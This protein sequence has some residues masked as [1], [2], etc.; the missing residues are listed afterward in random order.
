MANQPPPPPVLGGG[1]LGLGTGD[2]ERPGRSTSTTR[3]TV[4][5]GMGYYP[6]DKEPTFMFPVNDLEVSVSP[7]GRLFQPPPLARGSA[8]PF[9]AT[10]YDEFTR[11]WVNLSIGRLSQKTVPCVKYRS[12]EPPQYPADDHQVPDKDKFTVGTNPDQQAGSK[13]VR[14]LHYYRP[15]YKGPR[16]TYRKSPDLK[17]QLLLLDRPAHFM[18]MEIAAQALT[19]KVGELEP[20]FC[21]LALY[22][23]VS[24]VGKKGAEV[25]LS[26]SGRVS[27]TFWFDMNSGPV[28]RKFSHVFT[29]E[30]PSGPPDDVA[31]PSITLTGSSTRAAAG[32]SAVRNKDARRRG[33]PVERSVTGCRRALFALDPKNANGTLF[34]VLQLS[35]VLQGEPEKVRC[36]KGGGGVKGETS[37]LDAYSKGRSKSNADSAAEEAAQR[38]WRYRQPLAF[39]V[40]QVAPEGRLL[41]GDE[42]SMSL[43]R[44]NDGLSE[45]GLMRQAIEVSA[46][47]ASR[48]KGSSM[49]LLDG[50]FT[51]A[52]KP[53]GT[54]SEQPQLRGPKSALKIGDGDGDILVDSNLSVLPQLTQEMDPQRLVREVQALPLISANMAGGSGL[55]RMYT[56]HSN[57]M[58]VY[59]QGLERCQQRN[60]AI[61]VEL[62]LLPLGKESRTSVGDSLPAIFSHQLGPTFVSECYA[63]TTYHSRT[64]QVCDEIKVQLPE[65]LTPRHRLVFTVFHVHVKRKTGGMFAKSGSGD[66]QVQF[67]IGVASL[68]LMRKNGA[69]LPDDQHLIILSPNAN[70][71]AASIDD[72][73][74]DESVDSTM[75][76]NSPMSASSATSGG[77]SMC[78]RV[79]TRAVS[80]LYT[81]DPSLAAFLAQQPPPLGHLKSMAL[82]PR[83]DPGMLREMSSSMEGLEYATDRMQGASEWAVEG[84]FLVTARALLRCLC[85]G[86]GDMDWSWGDP[87]AHHRL[88]CTAFIS[89]L[90]TLHKCASYFTKVDISTKVHQPSQALL[91]AWVEHL[92]DEEVPVERGAHDPQEQA[93]EKAREM[94]ELRRREEEA[95]ER[96]ANQAMQHVM[97]SV[98][99]GLVDHFTSEA[100]KEKMAEERNSG[101]AT[102][103]G[104]FGADLWVESMVSKGLKWVQS[105]RAEGQTG[106]GEQGQAMSPRGRKSC[107]R[108][109]SIFGS[110]L[111]DAQHEVDGQSAVLDANAG[112][113]SSAKVGRSVNNGGRKGRGH[114][115]SSSGSSLS[116]L[117][118]PISG[119]AGGRGGSYHGSTAG[120][121]SPLPSASAASCGS[122]SGA[123]AGSMRLGG[124]SIAGFAAQSGTVKSGHVLAGITAAGG[125]GGA[126]SRPQ[127]LRTAP[128]SPMLQEGAPQQP[129]APA[130]LENSHSFRAQR[131]RSQSSPR[132]GRVHASSMSFSS[133]ASVTAGAGGG[134]S[135][136]RGGRE[137]KSL[138]DS[139][140]NKGVGARRGVGGDGTGYRRSSSHG[141]PDASASSS[142]SSPSPFAIAAAAAAAAAAMRRASSQKVFRPNAES[143]AAGG[144]APSTGTNAGAGASASASTNAGGS[145]RLR[146]FEEKLNQGDGKW[147]PWVYEVL[148]VQ[149]TEVLATVR[150]GM[151]EPLAGRRTGAN[152]KYPYTQETLPNHT[153]VLS[154]VYAPVL[155]AMILKSISLR[156]RHEK[157]RTPVRLDDSFLEELETLV[158]L[159]ARHISEA[160]TLGHVDLINTSLALF[161]RDLFAVV[162]PAHA[163]RLCGAYI[164]ALRSKGDAPFETQFTLG[165]LRRLAMHDHLVALNYPRLIPSGVHRKTERDMAVL[166]SALVNSGFSTRP[167]S[168][169][170]GGYG[171]GLGLSGSAL[172][173]RV[174]SVEY[175]QAAATDSLEP[176]WLLELCIQACMSATEHEIQAVRMSGLVLLREL[177]VFH[178]YDYRY[179]DGYSR[180][181]VAAMYL[182]LIHHLAAKVSKLDA[183]HPR[184]PERRE[185]LATLLYVLQDAPEALLREMWKDVGIRFFRMF[186]RRPI[187]GGGT[188]GTGTPS[189]ANRRRSFNFSTS[190]ESFATAS[191]GNRTVYSPLSNHATGGGA[192][193][194]G[195]GW[196]GGIGGSVGVGGAAA[197]SSVRMGGLG[198]GLGRAAAADR[199]LAGANALAPLPQEVQGAG[200]GYLIID[201][202][203]VFRI[204]GL[205]ELCIDT[206]EYP[207]QPVK[208]GG[209]ATSSTSS[210][211]SSS[212]TTGSGTKEPSVLVPGADG[213]D[214]KLSAEERA[215]A[216]KWVSHQAQSIV[217]KA[218]LVLMD[219]CATEVLAREELRPAPKQL[220]R[221]VLSSL[222]HALSVR[223][224]DV[225]LV[226]LF[227]GAIDFLRRYG[228]R[229]F[230][231]SVGDRMQDWLRSTLIYCNAQRY[232]LRTAGRNFLTYLLRSAFHYFGSI[233]VVRQPLM[234]VFQGMISC[235]SGELD[236]EERRRGPPPASFGGRRTP[237]TTVEDAVQAL[238]PLDTTLEEMRDRL[239]SS[240]PSFRHRMKTFMDE[241][242]LV[243]R[244]YLIKLR[245]LKKVASSDGTIHMGLDGYASKY[246]LGLGVTDLDT[247][248]VQEI[249]MQ[250]AS[251]FKSTELPKER[252]DWLFTLAEY[253][254]MLNNDAEQG[255]CLVE[256]YQG[257]KR[258][259]PIWDQLWKMKTFSNTDSKPGRQSD[260]GYLRAQI[261]EEENQVRL[262]PWNS[263]KELKR[264][265]IGH[266]NQAG[267]RLGE[268]ALPLLANEAYRETLAVARFERDYKIMAQAH[269]EIHQFMKKAMQQET[270]GLGG[271][272]AFFRVGFWGALPAELKGLEFVYRVPLMTHVSDFQNRVLKLIYPLVADPTKVKVLPDS[273]DEAL[274]ADETLAYIKITSVKPVVE[275]FD[276][277]EG[278]LRFTFHTPFTSAG[279]VHGS[280]AEQCKKLTELEVPLPFP[281]CTSRQIVYRRVVTLLSPIECSID[282]IGSRIVVMRDEVQA[283]IAR[284]SDTRDLTR[285][286]QGSVLPQ[287]N[288]GAVEV[289]ETFLKALPPEEGVDLPPTTPPA[290]SD[291]AGGAGASAA[292]AEAAAGNGN[293]KTKS[294]SGAGGAAGAAAVGAEGAEAAEAAAAAR[295]AAPKQQQQQPRFR[296]IA[297][298]TEE[299]ASELRGV[300]REMLI[301]FLE[302]CRQLV[303]KTRTV[304]LN[305]RNTAGEDRP[306]EEEHDTV[307]Q[308]EMERGFSKMMQAMEVYLQDGVGWEGL[309]ASTKNYD[310]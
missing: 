90:H 209:S 72:S 303:V 110:P 252:A 124:G 246:W 190:S 78:I 273:A 113:L 296:K 96:L 139:Y 165:F 3:G 86:K 270:V 283:G 286:V 291:G 51:F 261:K 9:L 48:T 290:V 92:M 292:T 138:E 136:I 95:V 49:T 263:E 163:A 144:A 238:A 141:V 150:G 222:L 68:P 13:E 200:V 195:P 103:S 234:A 99:D 53:M 294:G 241:L 175:D 255:R 248:S 279:K 59:V 20:V 75:L 162:H 21:S 39:G 36:G 188:N 159:L 168:M 37:V 236:K 10:A 253:H 274:V 12:E 158:V 201:E 4:N 30:S 224:S 176:H 170:S 11:N 115:R 44:Q 192:G 81:Q 172:R 177:Q 43:H 117:G 265:I 33:T 66:E 111:P 310:P 239:P 166:S 276:A 203:Q 187:A 198:L 202:Y 271:I 240:D 18:W 206:F 91:L 54:T 62:R 17:L 183:M 191:P 87:N 129:G 155:L 6:K 225:C 24:R 19:F 221:R 208:E 219:E 280:T 69:L 153:T 7:R 28:R 27:E 281:C 52:V 262:R 218:T 178:T 142:T 55:N 258:C 93:R 233:G 247:E 154:Q 231:S 220:V 57:V 73:F 45:E 126:G 147:W 135:P 70:A 2:P 1:R 309:K 89:L 272:G 82:N 179:Q 108:R 306:A 83:P 161:I 14:V 35:K 114:T 80:S 230:V 65:L 169:P 67:P 204:L 5:S 47:E 8:T 109:S 214:S 282:D 196:A 184:D 128:P 305:S 112:L 197:G 226:R 16:S 123:R 120:S 46:A 31:T 116:N 63:Q 140:A 259:L 232:R 235:M 152:S 61:R 186:S 216:T 213:P 167:Y 97:G 171:A 223:Q 205:L 164:R 264:D 207:G 71:A 74:R 228:A 302:L 64:P 100:I 267:A 42:L 38:L 101:L 26:R 211:S 182:P 34:L 22:R 174:G 217:R 98:A 130:P 260:A 127:S 256:I 132:R 277:G 131:L 173:P 254:K 84:H 295:A 297:L 229:V 300:L 157:L 105:W 104:E 76:T 25:D 121:G 58:Y 308:G 102:G 119:G 301:E 134:G 193:R 289:A 77:G 56:F 249:F 106:S 287:V 40:Y 251:V 245:Y 107:P 122:F 215:K 15:Q 227:E 285:L 23:I 212:G 50:K 185:M 32:A 288:G 237:I 41:G 151:E 210:S 146:T 79:Q 189:P 118:A 269:H 60:L 194:F 268:A 145:P 143:A 160:Q 199:T 244:A 242:L 243:K 307:W 94:E 266:A 299:R 257:F 137:I 88:R 133:S 278:A 149:W 250:A 284:E 298:I 125:V 181:R 156:V 85:F 29:R 180:Q 148:V 293:G 304:L 275:V